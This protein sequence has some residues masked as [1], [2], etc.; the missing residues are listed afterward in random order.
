VNA[1]H[2]IELLLWQTWWSW[3]PADRSWHAVFVHTFNL[4]EGAVWLAFSGLV[5]RR[6]IQRKNSAW[7][8]VYALAFLTFG[9]S[10]L[11]EAYSLTSWLIWFKLVN[12]VFLW[13]LRQL[14][15]TQWYPENRIY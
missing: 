6:Y 15:R 11:V 2:W 4:M 13:K 3:T 7:E 5:V 14:V 9:L 10:D 8:L 12:L 1:S